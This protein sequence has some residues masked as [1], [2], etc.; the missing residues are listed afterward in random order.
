MSQ[1]YGQ[2]EATAAFRQSHAEV[3]NEWLSLDLAQREVDFGLYRSSLEAEASDVLEAVARLEP[4]QRLVPVSARQAE[5][6]V[7]RCTL[8]ALL[9]RLKHESA[10]QGTPSRRPCG[11]SG[12]PRRSPAALLGLR[13]A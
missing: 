4:H 13:R 9:E 10:V 7:F 1:I 11:T 6:E 12:R 3:F 5:C 2:E 8:I